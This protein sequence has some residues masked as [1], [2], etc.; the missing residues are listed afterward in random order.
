MFLLYFLFQSFSCIH[1][2]I[3][4]GY[5]HNTYI[6]SFIFVKYSFCVF[7]SPSFFFL[8][9]SFLF[10]RFFLLSIFLSVALFYSS[11]LCSVLFCLIFR[12]KIP[13]IYY[14]NYLESRVS[15]CKTCFLVDV[16]PFF[17]SVRSYVA[18][19]FSMSRVLFVKQF[20]VSSASKQFLIY[21][22]GTCENFLFLKFE[23]FEMFLRA[24]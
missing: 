23:V 4:F 10:F 7:S 16:Y 6:S 13:P 14:Y 20:P 3:G 1:P 24:S 17:R 5:K 9:L 18:N 19:N 11:F 2:Y 22:H 8:F 12:L 21:T 15:S